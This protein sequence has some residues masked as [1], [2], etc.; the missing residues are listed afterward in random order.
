VQILTLEEQELHQIAGLISEVRRHFNETESQEFLDEIGLYAHQLPYRIRQLMYRFKLGYFSDGMCLLSGFAIDDDRL[1]PTPAHWRDSSDATSSLDERIFHFMCTSLLGEV[2]G[3]STQQNGRIIHD[4][5][6]IKEYERSQLGFSS[7]EPLTWHTEDSFHDY[8]PDY[9]ALMCLRNPDRIGTHCSKPDYATLTDEQRSYLFAPHYT[10]KPD[11]SHLSGNNFHA[12]GAAESAFKDIEEM[13]AAPKKL[14]VL[15]GNPDDPYLRID[16]YFM[17]PA[18]DPKA[19]E[20]L[21]TLIRVIDA[22]YREYPMKQGEVMFINNLRVVH[23]RRSFN[24]RYDGK[25]RWLKRLLISRDLGKSR[26]R[27]ARENSRIIT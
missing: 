6:P 5:F 7:Q 12:D 8:R 3:W 2:F 25:D 19:Q 27:R 18:E 11:N 4:V 9:L 21:E 26:D 15:F 14:S 22:S 20:A 17:A 23:G 10:I 24:A 1:G 13:K 16:P